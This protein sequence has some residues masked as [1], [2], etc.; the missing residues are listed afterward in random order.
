MDLTREKFNPRHNPLLGGFQNKKLLK[1]SQTFM[2]D[3]GQHYGFAGST[4]VP[5]NRKKTPQ[6]KSDQ[7]IENSLR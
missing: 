4:I 1:M 3:A 2:N 7:A 5:E 6:I